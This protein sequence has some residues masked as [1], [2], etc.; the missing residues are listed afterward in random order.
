MTALLGVPAADGTMHRYPDGVSVEFVR[1]HANPVLL[2]VLSG[3]CKQG[4][5][6]PGADTCPSCVAYELL[7]STHGA[8][9][10]ADTAPGVT[11]TKTDTEFELIVND[12]STGPVPAS[13]LPIRLAAW[14]KKQQDEPGKYTL[15]LRRRD[16]VTYESDWVTVPIELLERS[17]R[18]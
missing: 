7:D 10:G 18:G 12:I 15:T 17:E 11:L 14:R 2:I 8:G 13:F 6:A 3:Y 16:F 4:P 9:V 1:T 5:G